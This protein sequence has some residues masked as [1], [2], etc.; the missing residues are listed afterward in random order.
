MNNDN[1]TTLIRR[2]VLVRIIKA[3]LSD[4]FYNNVYKIPYV[5]RPKN[6]EVP[7]R[8]C[9]HKERAILRV[10]TLT[11]L[12]FAIEDDD[13]MTLLSDYA[14][15]STERKPE[16]C[17]DTSLTVIGTACK[18]CVPSRIYVTELC[19]G[20]IAQSCQK[21]CNFGAISFDNGRAVI[22]Q[23]NCKNCSICIKACPYEAIQKI[24]V[25]C[26]KACPVDAIHKNDIGIAEIDYDKCINCGACISHCPFGAV[27]ERSRIIDILMAIKEGKQVIAMLAPAI[28]GQFPVPIENIA[29][30]LI[31]AGFSKVYEVAQGADKTAAH[32]AE[33]F[34]ERMDRGDAFMTTSCCAS[35]NLLVDK[36][37]PELTSYVS[38]TPTP[39]Y[40]TAD[41]VKKEH[42]NSVSVFVG[43]CTSK[44]AEGFSNENVDYVMSIEELGVLF[45]A[46]EIYLAK[47]EPYTFPQE[48]SAE[49][50]GF[51]VSGGVSESVKAASDSRD[52]IKEFCV[53]GLDKKSIN[54]LKAYAKMGKCPSGN[55]VE[56]MSCVGGCVGGTGTI[57]EQ[58]FS[59]KELKEYMQRSRPIPQ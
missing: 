23:E 56:V 30:G 55:L 13:E 12:G 33:D 7:Y 48:A 47:C 10:R 53:N 40:Y 18:G 46:M 39:L 29:G 58:K 11:G 57:N 34:K 32:E 45:V 24:I 9:T 41:I 36:H 5:M 16:D 28:V 38:D 6:S 22:N 49:A 43:P 51:S 25:P 15:L 17:T 54:Q 3:F 44:R 31:E 59:T 50:R 14:K 1:N 42:P 52:A 8:C 2:E 26:E 21:S 37:V 20:C 19:Q 4:D 27:T 35:Y